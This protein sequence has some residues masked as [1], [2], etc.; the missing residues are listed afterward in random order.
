LSR[1]AVE[2]D[3]ETGSPVALRVDPVRKHSTLCVADRMPN[4]DWNLISGPAWIHQATTCE[5][6]RPLMPICCIY[7]RRG[8]PPILAPFE[9][10]QPF[11]RLGSFFK[12]TAGR[13]S[14][15]VNHDPDCA[16]IPRLV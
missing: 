11:T 13:A 3:A 2:A 1:G 14:S 7:H 12:K 9:P 6:A 4:P 10:G 5:A 15:Q 16:G 8:S